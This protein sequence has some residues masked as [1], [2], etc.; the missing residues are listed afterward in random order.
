MLQVEFF[1]P[2]LVLAAMIEATTETISKNPLASEL[3]SC[4][5]AQQHYQQITDSRFPLMSVGV[6]DYNRNTAVS[7]QLKYEYIGPF[8]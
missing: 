2:A 1:A 4:L 5:S 7:I 3:S 6:A 8:L